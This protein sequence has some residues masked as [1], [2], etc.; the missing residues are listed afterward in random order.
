MSLPRDGAGPSQ[1]YA[2]LPPLERPRALPGGL[3]AGSALELQMLA[4]GQAPP[5][6]PPPSY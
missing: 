6:P 5:P 4:L 3:G 2:A 1:A